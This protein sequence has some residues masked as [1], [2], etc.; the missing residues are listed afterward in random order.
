MVT[1]AGKRYGFEF[2]YTDAPG[3]KRSMHIAIQDLGL[4][5]L[6]VVY[7]GDHMYALDK[8]IT[9]VPLKAIR[10]LPIR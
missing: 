9:V 8:K 6:W 5:H 1:C 7:P 2:K 4:T 3:R 10:T